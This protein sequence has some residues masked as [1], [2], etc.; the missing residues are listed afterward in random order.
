MDA[1]VIITCVA[2]AAG[3]LLLVVAI[4]RARSILAQIAGTPQTRPWRV[5]VGL[6][7]AFVVGYLSILVLLT[8]GGLEAATLIVGAIF[9]GGAFFVA[10]VVAVAQ[11]TIAATIAARGERDAAREAS[12]QKSSFLAN[13]SHELRTPLNATIGYAELI[14]EVC[15]DPDESDA[16]ARAT[17]LADSA[18]ITLAGRH[19]LGLIDGILDLS[20]IEAGKMALVDEAVDL[21]ALVDEVLAVSEPLARSS[22][23]ELRCERPPALGVVGSDGLR[24]RQ[25]LLNLLSNACKFTSGGEVCLEITA[26]AAR[27][28]FEIQDTGIGISREQMGRLFEPFVQGDARTTRRFGGS[29][30]G[31]ALSRRFMELLGGRVEVSSEPGVGS[32]FALVLPRRPAP[33]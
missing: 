10:L 2:V 15:E 21:D 13:M 6:M 20:K 32:T 23:N 5:L 3:A 29:G 28:R 11:S 25:C 4:H 30:L 22:G 14:Q 17:A 12:A 9:L 8:R 33:R 24:L 31:L 7:A 16:A 18:R 27:V 19:L 1:L 26:D